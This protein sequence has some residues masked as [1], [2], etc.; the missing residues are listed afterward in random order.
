[1]CFK[2]GLYFVLLKFILFEYILI[3]VLNKYRL[4]G[5]FIKIGKVYVN[6]INN[7]FKMWILDVCLYE[8]I[9]NEV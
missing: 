6:I 8:M 1:M 5:M 7:V 3:R 4:I 9:L 2:N